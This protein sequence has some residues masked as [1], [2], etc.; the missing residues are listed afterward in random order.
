MPR[1]MLRYAIEKFRPD[2]RAA[3]LRREPRKRDAHDRARQGHRAASRP[4]TPTSRT[5]NQAV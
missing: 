2:L 5:V 1:T 4:G 3:Y